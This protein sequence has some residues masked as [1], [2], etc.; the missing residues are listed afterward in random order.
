MPYPLMVALLIVIGVLLF[1][2]LI[3]FHEL[4]H[5]IFAKASGIR[6]NEFSLGMGPKLFGFQRGE[7]LYA[8]RLFPI[9]G[10]CAMEGEDGESS[11]ERAFGN[12]PVW[13]RILVIVAGGVFNMI[14]G[15]LMLVILTGQEDV[16][17]TTTIAKFAD[18]SAAQT[19]GA[20]VGDR[21]VEI[22][23]YTVRTD[24]DLSFGFAMA[25]PEAITM[26]VMR[27]GETVE[28]GP[29]SMAAEGEDGETKTLSLDF[30]VEPGQR[31]FWNV[32]ERSALKT[33][34][35][36]RMVLAS[37]K[38]ILTGR[39]GFN[40]M[41]GPVGTAQ[42]IS[43]MAQM[44]L[45]SGFGEAVNNILYMM[46]LITVNLGVVNLLPLPALDGG[47]LLFLLWELI[48][49]KPVPPKYEGYVHAIGFI[50]LIGLML[51]VTGNDIWR[52]I[53]KGWSL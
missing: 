15:F 7:T 43:K 53:T 2:F 45:E 47:R 12:K 17:A 9:G 11:D 44:G 14:L 3:F 51:V 33:G 5:F 26:K 20:Q 42:A 48:T 6:V 31:T 38:G 19:A 32:L 8:L 13:K 40:E 36:V 39:F 4:G 24:Q 46:I 49:R 30:W 28:L 52:I 22:N 23:G 50:L 10:F 21:I 1:S 25:D 41:A 18:T 37:L 34:S 16:F 29:F 27:E 35:M